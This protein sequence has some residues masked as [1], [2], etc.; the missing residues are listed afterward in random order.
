VNGG[1]AR[2]LTDKKK[3]KGNFARAP[4]YTKPE[5][6]QFMPSEAQL[7]Q[8]IGSCG[9][10][11]RTSLQGFKETGADPRELAAMIAKD[12]NTESRTITLNHSVKGYKP[13]ITPV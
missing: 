4:K 9:K 6:V 10:V 7:N 13:R 3:R 1:R 5:T 11:L 2:Y 12:I 8:L